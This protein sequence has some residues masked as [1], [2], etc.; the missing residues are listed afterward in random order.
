MA[1]RT[2]KRRFRVNPIEAGIFLL[3]CGVFIHS[4]YRLVFEWNDF[5]E[6]ASLTS[7]SRAIASVAETVAVE[8]KAEET[9]PLPAPAS[10][11]ESRSRSVA[12]SGPICRLHP[13]KKETPE[14]VEVYRTQDKK[15]FPGKIN[16]QA[17][18]FDSE[19]INLR[20]GKNDFE[21][22]TKY[23]SGT[24]VQKVSMMYFGK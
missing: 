14:S 7:Q 6:R 19:P 9:N 12:F 15:I 18:T 10:A 23:K 24:R 16:A 20:I 8:C 11:T 1:E 21:V 13:T 2:A 4:A 3:I 17:G 22:R 5:K